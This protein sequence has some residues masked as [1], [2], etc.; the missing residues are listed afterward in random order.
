V[1]VISREY[2]PLPWYLRGRPETGYWTEPPADCDGALVLVEP[3]QA[4]TV[5]T[6][7]RGR[8]QESFLGLRPGFVLVV[9]ARVD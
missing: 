7:L 4:G 1:K 9:F 8:Y 3:E 5:R 2:W 6:R